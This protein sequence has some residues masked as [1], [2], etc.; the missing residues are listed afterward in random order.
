[1]YIDKVVEIEQY[2]HIYIL[3][4]DICIYIKCACVY[5]CVCVCV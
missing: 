3:Y 5:A 2:E 1:M 4:E